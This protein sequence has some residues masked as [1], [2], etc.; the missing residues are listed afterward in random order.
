MNIRHLS[1]FTAA[2][3]LS[4]CAVSCGEKKENK[5]T[6]EINEYVDY[7]FSGI[8]SK[9]TCNIVIDYEKMVEENRRAFGLKSDYSDDDLA[10]VVDKL[11]SELQGDINTSDFLSNGDNIKFIWNE[12][13]IEKIEDEYN[14][15]IKYS[16]LDWSVSGLDEV[17]EIDPFESLEVTFS[18]TAPN[19]KM[20]MEV[21]QKAASANDM[22]YTFHD[23]ADKNS[24]LKNGDVV[25]ISIEDSD[26]DI[27]MAGF[28]ATQRSKEYT[29]EGLDYY[30]ESF[31]DIPSDD[32]TIMEQHNRDLLDAH[33]ASKWSSDEKCKNVELIKYYFLT[34][35]DGINV[36][37][38]NYLYF[39]YKIDIENPEGAA[40]Y[41][42][43][44]YYPDIL[45]TSD[46]MCVY[47]LNEAV[48]PDGGVYLSSSTYG[49]ALMVGKYYYTG[50]EK[51][52]DLY[53]KHVTTRIAD[54][55]CEEI[56]VE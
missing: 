4:A 45:I 39:I 40:T 32:I 11:E 17:V 43:Y 47:D 31:A 8:D 55:S 52:E 54:Y 18:G 12:N 2:L 37:T 53:N 22:S 14:I 36:G 35:K 44:T 21:L 49:E 46:D 15:N 50:Y 1:A 5:K 9:G 41:Y 42:Y 13:D 26:D 29:V 6:V 20:D 10:E 34:G 3:V 27:E 38:K 19:G 30:A 23:N 25:T 51:L 48:V 16:T 56:E 28:S 33:I 7:S 24:E